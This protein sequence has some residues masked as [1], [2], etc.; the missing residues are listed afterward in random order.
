M[1]YKWQRPASVLYPQVWAT[2]KGNVTEN[3]KC[4]EYVI[5]DVTED[6]YEDVL[7]HMVRYFLVREPMCGSL[8]KSVIIVSFIADKLSN[9]EL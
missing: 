6:M 1:S 7:Q 4:L 9:I 3:G 8:G 2:F 5:Q